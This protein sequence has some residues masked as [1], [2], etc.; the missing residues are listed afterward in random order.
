[1]TA[2]TEEQQTVRRPRASLIGL[3][4]TGVLHTALVIAQPIAAG[5]FLAGNVDAM[6]NVHGPIGGSI[7][8]V[9]LLQTV[10]AAVY[11]L[12][13]RGRAWPTLVS[14]GLVIA[15]FVQLTYGY[16]QNFAVHVPLGVAIVL[17]IIWFTIWSFRPTAR[18]TRQE[19]K[20]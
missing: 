20:R 9:G 19:A 18:L 10:V 2:T 16:Q 4:I 3:R 14:A 11:W 12:V 15:E 7:W 6:T 17:T 13:G 5:Y 8:M 1:M